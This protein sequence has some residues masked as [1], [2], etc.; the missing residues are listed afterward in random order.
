MDACTVEY[1]AI[2]GILAARFVTVLTDD[3]LIDFYAKAPHYIES[4]IVRAGIFDL[5]DVTS[6][7]VSALTLRR[8]AAMPPLLDE[9]IPRFVIAPQA[10]IYGMAR[11]F[12]LISFSR[13]RLQVVHQRQQAYDEL[14][15]PEPRFEIVA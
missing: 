14:G 4:R 2:G 10:H 13:G 12:Q 3:T 15:T 9:P 8:I 11:M 7:D 1:D 5:T 6:F